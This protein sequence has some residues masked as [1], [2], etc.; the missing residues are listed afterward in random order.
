MKPLPDSGTDPRIELLPTK[1][2]VG[3]CL[4]M[5]QK[6]DRTAELWRS[7]MPA[8]GQVRNRIGRHFLSMQVYP[9][10]GARILTPETRFQK[11]AVVEVSHPGDVPDGMMSYVLQGGKYAVFVHNGPAIAFP[12]TM[13]FISQEWLPASG[14][15]VDSREHFE[16]LEEGYSPTDPNAKEEVWIPIR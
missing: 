6:E 4:E 16:I 7:F 5:S 3:S 15:A 2:L 12:K 8:R 10:M 1:Q 11:W 14:H 9:P 13:A